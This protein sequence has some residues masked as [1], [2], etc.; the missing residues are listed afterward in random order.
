MG[1]YTTNTNKIFYFDSEDFDKIKD[2]PWYEN[3]YGYITSNKNKKNISL[4]RFLMNYNGKLQIDHIDVDKLNNKKSN[5]RIATPDIQSKNKKKS[6]KK[7]YSS[8]YKGVCLTKTGK[9]R[10]SIKSNYKYIHIGMFDTEEE[11]ALAY[12]KVALK[13]GFDNIN[14]ILEKGEKNE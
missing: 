13:L 11:A 7:K 8:I 9:W 4:S 12:N 14:I 3:S 6:Q 5:L 1:G 10:A 2:L